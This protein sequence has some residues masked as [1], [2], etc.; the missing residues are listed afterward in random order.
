MIVERIKVLR[1]LAVAVALSIVG[2][3]VMAAPAMAA[4]EIALTPASGALGTEVTVSGQNFESYRGDNISIYFDGREVDTL[5]VP[6]S[7][8]F[9][10]TFVVP[11][12][13]IAGRVYVS[14]RDELDNQLGTR[15]PFIVD[16]MEVD[17][18]PAD[19]VVGTDVT[20]L[21]K[22]FYASEEVTVYYSGERVDNGVE[23]AGPTGEF[24]YSFTVP[25]STAGDHQVRV[26]DTLGNSEGAD[27]QVI[28]SIELD[29]SSGA[30]RD[31]ITVSGIG[32]GDRVD[33][34][35]EFDRTDVVVEQTGRKGS[36]EAVFNVPVKPPGN[37]DIKV[38]DDDGNEAETSFAITAGIELS[39]YEGNV[40]T[41]LTVSGIGFMVNDAVVVK[42]DD[43]QVA[44]AT[45]DGNGAFS[46]TVVV[47][48]SIAGNHTVA[49]SDDIN[50]VTRIFTMESSPPPAPALL[51]PGDGDEGK[52]EAFF[53]WEAVHDPSGVYYTLQIATDADF[54]SLVLEKGDLP[55]SDYIL[56][57]GEKLSP[58]DKDAPY[59]W[60]VKAV[61][62][63]SNESSWSEAGSL[64]VTSGRFSLSAPARNALIAVG[65]TGG[66]FFGF[67]LGRRTSYSKV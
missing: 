36:F 61:D 11:D 3:I 24:S 7:G 58:T 23:T 56:E 52:P 65:I 2:V 33:V 41:T 60:R 15:R 29:R 30:T 6:D 9:T 32:F 5:V 8:S 59:Y 50:I 13:A 31:E 12:D 63:A 53:S 34:T 64:Y 62:G 10:S 42:Y 39:Q 21:G 54:A 27:F 40:G 26:E 66:V 67:W 28:P 38:E 43:L 35:V 14:V 25:E 46:A 1:T 22:G 18:R 55:T 51:L 44:T 20:I 37:Y 48:A 16:D 17:L 47:P 49:A 57:A 45:T 19:G 4:P